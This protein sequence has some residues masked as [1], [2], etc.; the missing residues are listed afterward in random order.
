MGRVLLLW[1]A[2]ET[3]PFGQQQRWF[4]VWQLLAVAEWL[5]PSWKQQRDLRARG[6]PG[7]SGRRLLL[8]SFQQFREPPDTR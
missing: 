1:V 7:I 5:S 4:P 2:V 8:Q 3:R 6:L